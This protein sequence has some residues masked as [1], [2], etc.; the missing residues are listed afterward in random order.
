MDDA[1]LLKDLEEHKKRCYHK[2]QCDIC[3]I[4]THDD[5]QYDYCGKLSHRYDIQYVYHCHCDMRTPLSICESCIDNP[6]HYEII[7]PPSD[8][9]NFEGDYFNDCCPRTKRAL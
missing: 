5:Q 1:E 7:E 3:K 4:E 8:D 9:N 2:T 6:E